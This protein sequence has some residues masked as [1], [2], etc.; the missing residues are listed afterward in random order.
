[1]KFV[2]LILAILISLLA[3]KPGLDY[4]YST[5]MDCEI[6][7]CDKNCIPSSEKDASKGQDR[8]CDGKNCN[9][10]QVCNSCVLLA[11]E[12]YVI[13]DFINPNI[14]LKLRFTYQ[15]AISSQYV[16]DF[17]QPPKFV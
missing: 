17:W 1:M 4:V 16:F 7:L 8:D 13:D 12:V 10:F 3:F 14:N 5:T 2:S 11:T 9:P 6:N 15:S